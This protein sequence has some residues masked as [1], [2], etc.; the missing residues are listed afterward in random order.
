MAV[1]AAQRKSELTRS[2]I[3]DAAARVF[4]DRGYSGGTLADIAAEIGMKAGSLYYHFESREELVEAVMSLGLARARAAVEARLAELP[5]RASALDRLRAAIE[6]HL[7]MV[8]EQE[9]YTSATIKLIWQVPPEIRERQLAA[10]RA[11]GRLWKR[12]IADGRRAGF[13]RQDLD[14]SLVR[15][16]IFGALNWAADWFRSGKLPA[17]RVASDLASLLL[18]GVSNPDSRS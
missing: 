16:G 9:H 18:E 1:R 5:V 11:Y 14:P 8:V 10:Q 17:R 13:L 6:A 4:R 3:L 15:M 12:L 7:L 2:S